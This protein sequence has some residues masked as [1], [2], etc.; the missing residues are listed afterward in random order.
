M[1]Y[2][3]YF[4]FAR[5]F[6]DS[7]LRSFVVVKTPL[8]LLFPGTW[9]ASYLELAAGRT[10]LMEWI[11]ALLTL[12]L[13]GA[14]AAGLGSRLSLDYSER[15][16]ALTSA[17]AP[18]GSTA[19]REPATTRWAR[20][21]FRTGEARAMALLIRSQFTNDQ[22]FRMAVLSI[23]PLTLLYVFM[24][25]QD[26]ALGDP[27][28]RR[29]DR[30][31]P[32][33][34]I[35]AVLMF[36]S[37]LKMSVTHSDTFRASWIFFSSP[38]NRMQLVRSAKNVLVAFFLV[39]YLLFVLAVYLYYVPRPLHV[40]VHLTL[41]GLVS[42]FCLQFMIFM[43]PDLPFSKPPMKG[44]ATMTMFMLIFTIIFF[45]AFF[46]ALA[47]RMY[48]SLPLTLAGFVAVLG[49]SALVD[50]FTRA[51]VERQM[52]SAEFEG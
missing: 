4:V 45:V 50:L 3:G 33:L 26:G 5:F 42:H 13:A 27:F 20:H 35:F 17:A 31:G 9:Y 44:R 41:L 8:V 21:L 16:G 51:R 14:L 12:V 15:L 34:V 52:R 7:A 25:V 19:A 22:R 43:D 2:G 30:S 49:A 47:P 39:P 38:A 32:S 36:P 24:G 10:G 28:D 29:A 48:Q 40:A 23:I 37:M 11:P 46:Q 18:R 6:Q 1:V